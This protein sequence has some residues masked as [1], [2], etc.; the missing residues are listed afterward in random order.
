MSR[1]RRKPGPE[2]TQLHRVAAVCVWRRG[3]RCGLRT[4]VC[5]VLSVTGE[6]PG[7]SV[8]C[9]WPG[10]AAS[11]VRAAAGLPRHPSH[12]T[13]ARC[14]D[15]ALC[16]LVSSR[17]IALCYGLCRCDCTTCLALVSRTA[18]VD[19]RCLFARVGPVPPLPELVSPVTCLCVGSVIFVCRSGN[20][21]A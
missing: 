19:I 11:A 3:E 12:P 13:G 15:S 18:G 8:D 6:A 5:P 14:P 1:R 10:D 7:G 16:R 2:P 20:L 9:R 4:A 21:L 17:H